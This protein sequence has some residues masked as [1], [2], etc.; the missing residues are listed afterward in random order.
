MKRV[1]SFLV[2][3]LMF[4]TAFADN[5]LTGAEEAEAV[6]EL[7]ARA[8]KI[9]HIDANFLQV[10]SLSLLKDEVKANG[11]VKYSAPSTMR[12]EY[13]SP[14]KYLFELKENKINITT[15]KGKN[16][17]DA[18]TSKMFK[19]IVDIIMQ[20]VTGKCLGPHS[21]FNSK[22]YLTSEGYRVDLAPKSKQLASMFKAVTLYIPKQS[23]NNLPVTK[24]VITESNADTTT[25]TF[26]AK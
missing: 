19:G 20:T 13:V 25:I 22:I 5:L 16:T 10:K 26:I 7:N 3:I 8:S 6:A 9:K 15:A 17:I 14:Y 24:V 1:I 21:R 11:T 2:L 4:S 18:S 23:N 12:W